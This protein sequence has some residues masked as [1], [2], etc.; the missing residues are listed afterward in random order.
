MCLAVD[1]S[2]LSYIAFA[3]EQSLAE[4]LAM[5][6]AARRV[7]ECDCVAF[8]NVGLQ[9]SAVTGRNRAVHLSEIATQVAQTFIV[10]QTSL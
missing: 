6:S 5:L 4:T 9:D 1:A 7:D 8:C 10:T 2:E 3:T